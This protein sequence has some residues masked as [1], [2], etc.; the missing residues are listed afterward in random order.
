MRAAEVSRLAMSRARLWICFLGPKGKSIHFA[1]VSLGR[2]LTFS[3]RLLNGAK[4]QENKR[5]FACWAKGFGQGQIRLV[6]GCQF[7][8]CPSQAF[9]FLQDLDGY[10]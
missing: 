4:T 5:E 10:L 1:D 9:P 8:I 2:L 6:V 7:A 3:S